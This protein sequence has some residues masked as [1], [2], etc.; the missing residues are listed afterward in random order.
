MPGRRGEIDNSL[1]STIIT[2][3]DARMPMAEPGALLPAFRTI[4][5]ERRTP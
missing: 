4:M 3:P 5:P 2:T 1:M